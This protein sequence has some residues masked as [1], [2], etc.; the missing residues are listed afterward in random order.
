MNF[1]GGLLR[2][3]SAA[4]HLRFTHADYPADGF[5]LDIG[6]SGCVAPAVVGERRSE[7]PPLGPIF[8]KIPLTYVFGLHIVNVN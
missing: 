2:Q 3:L 6:S 5:F 4:L 7:K 8:F 1:R